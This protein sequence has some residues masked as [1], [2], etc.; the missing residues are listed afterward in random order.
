MHALDRE[1]PVNMAGRRASGIL[2][3]ARRLGQREARVG[4]IAQIGTI[5]L[6][7]AGFLWLVSIYASGLRDPRYLDG[8]LLAGGM[9]LQLLFH[10]ALKTVRLPPNV[11]SAWRSFHIFLG[12]TLIAAFAA[13][14]NFGLPDT[15]FEWALWTGFVI[16]VL[17]GIA[18]AYLA[19]AQKA[20]SGGHHSIAY[21]RIPAR[22]IEIARAIEDVVAETSEPA[23]GAGL[24]ALPFDAWIDDLHRNHMQNFLAGP[25]NLQSHLIG[26][27]QPLKALIREIECVSRYVDDRGRERLALIQNLIIEKDGLDFAG[28][29]LGLLRLWLTIHLCATYALIMLTVLH[30]IVVYAFSSGTW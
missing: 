21:E 26:S 10:V 11:A 16:V 8:W 2:I 1:A 27:Q 28:V 19:W 6:L 4:P 13:H 24:P 30:V 15:A 22:R 25:R 9:A 3:G 5:V 20:K 23:P 29:H 18:A 17:S 14:G 7:S 12:L